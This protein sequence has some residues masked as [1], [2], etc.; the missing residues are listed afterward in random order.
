MAMAFAPLALMVPQVEIEDPMVVEKSYPA[1]WE[2]LKKA[3]FEIE[4]KR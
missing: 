1:Y 2:D 4:V 3:G